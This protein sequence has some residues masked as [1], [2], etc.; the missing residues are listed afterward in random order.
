MKRRADDNEDT[1]QAVWKRIML[2]PHL[3]DWYRDRDLLATVN[4]SDIVKVGE[5]IGNSLTR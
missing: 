2:K 4:G 3:A 5:E 1:V